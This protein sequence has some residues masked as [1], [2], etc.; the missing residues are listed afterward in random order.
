VRFREFIY[1]LTQRLSR[2]GISPIM[3]SEI[4]ELFQ[5]GRLAEY[6]IS[7]RSDNVVLL[8][9]LRAES[10]L[11]RNV[12]ILKSRA[13]AHDPEIRE[14][15]I[16]PGG[17]VLGH[18]VHRRAGLVVDDA[19]TAAGRATR[20]ASQVTAKAIRQRCP[21]RDP[22]FGG[23]LAAHAPGASLATPTGG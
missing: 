9:Y 12:T 16:T 4:P 5:V 13:S 1:S 23:R 21:V 19:H 7:H 14:F 17:I 8:Q 22:D 11:L 15:D 6:G 2:A 18:P 20:C 10:R 3:T